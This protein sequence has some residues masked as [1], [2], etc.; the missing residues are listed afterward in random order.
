MTLSWKI[1]GLLLLCLCFGSSAVSAQQ[2]DT[3]KQSDTAKIDFLSR[4]RKVGK[5]ESVS[6]ID[7]Y[8]A[9]RIS[10]RQE[11]LLQ[12]LKYNS[13][14]AKI[15]L[16]KGIDTLE[17]R[18]YLKR[19]S[20]NI[21]LIDEGIFINKGTVQSQ[22]NLA[23]TAAILNELLVKTNALSNVLSNHVNTMTG[24]IDRIDSLS[25]DSTLY[26]FPQDSTNTVKYL[27]RMALMVKELGPTDTALR[28]TAGY[29]QELQTDMDMMVFAVNSR[30]EEVEK[31]QT[32]LD[33]KVFAQEF[34]Y[35]WNP[36]SFNSPPTKILRFSLAKEMLALQFYFNQ[37]SGR[38][39]I[40]LALIF[41]SWF[42][43]HSLKQKLVAE[44]R[45]G[46]NPHVHV[47]LRFP[48]LSAIIIVCCIFQF[49]F[50][51][52]PYIFSFC[53]WLMM[54][55]C[56]AILFRGYLSRFGLQFWLTLVVLFVLA[57]ASNMVLQA[58]R[59]ERWY[60]LSLSLAGIFYGIYILSG[61]KRTGFTE[62]K[63]VYFIAFMIVMEIAALV[64]NISGRYNLSKSLMAV[65]FTGTLT[66]IEFLW[67]IR[68]INETLVLISRVYKHP[69]KK[70]FY[71][72]FDRIGEKAP[73]LFYVFLV[74]GWFIL[75]SRNF[76]GF[77]RLINPFLD[78]LNSDRTLGDYTFTINS[79]FIFI[80]IIVIS[81]IISQVISFFADSPGDRDD[82]QARKPGVGS[83]LLL[84]RIFVLSLGVY[85]AFAAAG[86]PMDRL[87]IILG[88][89]GVGI[90]L[91][92]Q[93]LVSN[94]VSGLIIAFE[95]PVN[96]GD[97]I[98]V[99]GSLGIMKSI[100]FRSSVVELIDGACLV[101]P[102]GDLLSSHLT[103]WTMGKNRRRLNVVVSVAYGS[104]LKQV[105]EILEKVLN[106]NEK[107]LKFPEP[108]VTAKAFQD[109]AV[110]FDM[111]YWTNNIIEILSMNSEIITQ[112]DETFRK[113]GIVIPF[114]RHD[115]HIVRESYKDKPE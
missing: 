26:T 11:Q 17:Y 21:I 72:N 67:T 6:S 61:K 4:V 82:Q 22:R 86:I 27:R 57:G 114:P 54:A 53:L 108:V 77:G 37:H 33:T 88:A 80:L 50:L 39:L 113:E 69:D 62:R 109:S 59:I 91:G 30:L 95:K 34:P 106:E 16:N 58:S 93:G 55:I 75:I 66:A 107:V 23:V 41:A 74:F 44:K 76:H 102:N 103:N 92:L 90:G 99:N 8:K 24:F 18:K 9:G 97:I 2:P 79:L 70:L 19:A 47:A 52:P 1:A 40:L 110:D 32:E 104:N 83:W 84:I 49:I 35:I 65:G 15:F 56:L 5:E 105:K 111:H 3:T 51:H 98:E 81:M 89:L 112:V 96:V 7:K 63:I 101:V 87:A 73:I 10:M 42:F 48:S 38:L 100:G 25:T 13:H 36:S 12:E 71:I 20:A 68:L 29:L 85:L 45:M 14:Q 28:S 64:A 94:L 78:F 46:N 43:L 115:L 60:M 31:L